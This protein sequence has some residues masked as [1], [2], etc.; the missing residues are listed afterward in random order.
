MFRHL[1]FKKIWELTSK[2]YSLLGQ[3]EAYVDAISNTPILPKHRSE[4]LQVA[5]VKGAQATTAIEGNTLSEEEIE[6][7]FDGSRLPPSKEYQEHEVKN[8]IN[9]FNVLLN[10]VVSDDRS[11]LITPDLICRF[12]EMVGRGLGENFDAEPGRF[13]SDSRVVGGYRGPDYRDVPDLINQYCKWLRSEFHYENGQ[14]FGDTVI[15]AVVAHIN[16]E[17]IHPFGDGNGRTGRLL[18]FY[19]LLR[20]GL[21]DIASHILSNHYN[22]TRPEYYRHFDY[23]R[24]KCDLTS[25][26]EY[27]LLGFRDGLKETLQ[28]IHRSQFEVTWSKYVYDAFKER[29]I[30]NK[31][32]FNRQRN[33]ALLIPHNKAFTTN[34]IVLATPEIAR[35]YANIQRRTVLSDLNLLVDMGMLVKQGSCE[36]RANKEVIWQLVAA[37]KENGRGA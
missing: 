23:A 20:G 3:C 2:S 35:D 26:I 9:A 5:L 10:E 16:M 30:T 28:I 24:H 33:L 31:R 25:F 12:H 19:I 18:E 21:P 1:Q 13:R 32:V 34:E 8:I 7:I 15:Q 29:K 37:R 6:K 22:Q 14:S 4:L 36:F 27:A 17:W 11:D